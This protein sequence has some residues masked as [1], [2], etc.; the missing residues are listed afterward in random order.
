M[1]NGCG[2][3]IVGVGVV[4]VVARG[5][6]VCS[7]CGGEGEDGRLV[8]T[9][10]VVAIVPIAV[11][12]AAPMRIARRDTVGLP[13]VFSDT[14][15]FGG[16]GGVWTVDIGTDESERRVAVA[17][18]GTVDCWNGGKGCDGG[19]VARGRNRSVANIP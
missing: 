15:K 10:T 3:V 9:N 11:T 13:V 1:K 12:L 4:P 7:V 19:K 17:R 5:V 2:E 6:T 8:M 16:I 14:G 18:G